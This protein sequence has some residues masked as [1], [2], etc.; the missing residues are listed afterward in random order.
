MEKRSTH[1]ADVLQWLTKVVDSCQTS[2]Q[3]KI[4]ERLIYNYNRIYEKKIGHKECWDMVRPLE[5]K[6]WELQNPIFRK[7]LIKE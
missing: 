7:K 2:E 1:W 6:L 3:A 4:C 5:K